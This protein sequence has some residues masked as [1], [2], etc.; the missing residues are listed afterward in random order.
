M[1]P[2]LIRTL[3]II[4]VVTWFAG[5]FYIVRLF[6]YHVEAADKP[7]P[8]REILEAQ[9]KVMEKRLWYGITWPSAVL[10]SVFGFWLVYIFNYWLQPW[11][12]LKFG[13]VA[14]LFFYHLLCG[15]LYRQLRRGIIKYTSLQLRMWN[16]VATLFLVAVVFVVEY[17]NLD[18]W[19]WGLFGLVMLAGVFFIGVRFYKK[20]RERKVKS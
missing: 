19:L 8:E 9:F 6:I 12:L 15:R 14:G 17:K 20:V 5:L 10:T 11:M 3:H 16:E 7:S 18:S 13:L 1:D 4:F 2:I